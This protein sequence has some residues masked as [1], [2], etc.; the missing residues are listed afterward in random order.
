MAKDWFQNLTHVPHIK[1][2]GDIEQGFEGRYLNLGV[3][4]WCNYVRCDIEN[5]SFWQSSIERD[6]PVVTAASVDVT[7]HNDTLRD[8]LADLDAALEMVA[9]ITSRSNS[10]HDGGFRRART[11]GA[12]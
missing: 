11:V 8:A 7:W 6:D 9:N 3:D 5:R 2:Q 1:W 10:D 4:V 12:G